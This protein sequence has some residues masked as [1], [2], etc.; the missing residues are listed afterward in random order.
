M[1]P[2]NNGALSSAHI[3]HNLPFT[4]VSPALEGESSGLHNL[5]LILSIVILCCLT[6]ECFSLGD[7]EPHLCGYR[8]VPCPDVHRLQPVDDG[9]AL[10][11]E[12]VARDQPFGS[13][14]VQLSE[15]R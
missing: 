10:G 8:P 11:G 1:P 15:R 6:C 9:L 14:L 13:K 5:K 2:V 4:V 3:S 7:V 12:F